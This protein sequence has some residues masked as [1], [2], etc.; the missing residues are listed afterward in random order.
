MKKLYRFQYFTSDNFPSLHQERDLVSF[1][2]L[3][4]ILYKEGYMYKD[5]FLNYPKIED[6]QS[7]LISF[8]KNDLMLL[9]TRP[10]Y[11]DKFQRRKIYRTDH[12]YEKQMLKQI[13]RNVCFTSLSRQVM[14]LRKKLAMQLKEGYEDRASISFYV[15]RNKD[16]KSAGY[17]QVSEYGWGQ[18]RKWKNWK[19]ISKKHRSCAFLI[20][21]KA[22]DLLPKMLYVF[23]MGGEEGLFFSR[24]LRNGLWD[25][26]N[27]NLNGPS[28][29]IMVELDIDFPE[30]F[31]T[32]FDFIKD[33]NYD[34]ILDTELP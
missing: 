25:K 1:V 28:R 19:S 29:F 13:G 8:G 30:K 34:V 24:I 5:S 6:K 27:I 23:G 31:P 15:H 7:G 10:P 3:S 11:S 2:E 33:L 22:K 20:F 26:L 17:K 18:I 14:F 21:L 9:T 32:N 12:I 16:N 4:N